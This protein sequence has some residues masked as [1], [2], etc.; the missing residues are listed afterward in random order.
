VS[1]LRSLGLDARSLAEVLAVCL[2]VDTGSIEL[3]FR[4]GRLTEA[5]RHER[6]KATEMARV[7]RP[8]TR[9]SWPDVS[10]RD[11]RG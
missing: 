10:K 6:L 7:A 2:N 3:V 5:Y 11:T 4:D 8:P 1:L 9:V